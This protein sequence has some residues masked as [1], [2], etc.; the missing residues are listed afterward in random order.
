MLHQRIDI[1][2]DGAGG[3]AVISFRSAGGD[4][5]V[6]DQTGQD[7][8]DVGAVLRGLVPQLPGVCG[9]G[10]QRGHVRRAAGQH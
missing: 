10:R 4:P 6:G 7:A 2:Q 3:P 5:R 1:G 9:A 8:A